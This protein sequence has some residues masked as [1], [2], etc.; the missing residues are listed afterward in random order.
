[1]SRNFVHFIDC[2]NTG[3]EK[4]N[5]SNIAS[6]LRYFMNCTLKNCNFLNFFI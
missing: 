6:I 3:I 2:E 4:G 1:M 5:R